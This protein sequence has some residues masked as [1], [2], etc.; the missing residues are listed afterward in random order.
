MSET[1]DLCPHC[2]GIPVCPE[3]PECHGCHRCNFAGTLAGLKE[4]EQM[5]REAHEA[6]VAHIAAGICGTCGATC[7][8]EA[9][10]KCRPPQTDNGDDCCD[11]DH[12]WAGQRLA[13]DAAED[14]A[15][16][17][18]DSEVAGI[19]SLEIKVIEAKPGSPTPHLGGFQMLPAPPGVCEQCAVAHAPEA[20]HNAQSMHYQYR[21]FGRHGRWPTW[22]DALAHCT[23]ELRKQWEDA[24]LERGVA[25]VQLK[26]SQ[27]LELEP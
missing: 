5:E 27:H 14:E 21:F 10:Q 22:G 18:E 1:L 13:E 12:L 6:W 20:P 17:A 9:R 8:A 15:D 19:R 4:M 26:P 16:E 2:L 23:P 11:G 24:L 3:E 7:L 25:R